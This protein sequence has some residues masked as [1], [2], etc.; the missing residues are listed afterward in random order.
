M[1]VAMRIKL[2]FYFIWILTDSINNAVGLG[3]NGYDESTGNAKWD[4]T[5]NIIIIYT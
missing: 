1:V 2:G 5:T 3:F 4:L